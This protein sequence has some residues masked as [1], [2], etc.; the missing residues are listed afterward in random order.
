MQSPEDIV[1]RSGRKSLAMAAVF[2]VLAAFMFKTSDV[3]SWGVA[4]GFLLTANAAVRLALYWLSRRI[5]AK[6]GAAGSTGLSAP[7]SL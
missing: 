1:R 5:V 3:H 6:P 7:R 2:A 4:V